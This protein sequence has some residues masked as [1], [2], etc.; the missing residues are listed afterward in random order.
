MIG[1]LQVVKY[2]YASIN[3]ND[4]VL[5]DVDA[6]CL[7]IIIMLTPKMTVYLDQVFRPVL[8][9]AMLMMINTCSVIKYNNKNAC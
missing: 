9:L 7:F 5:L 2:L 6:E 3:A 8:T 1:R 4:H